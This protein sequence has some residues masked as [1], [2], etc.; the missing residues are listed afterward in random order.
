VGRLRIRD[1]HERAG[2][3]NHVVGQHPVRCAYPPQRIGT[4]D[5]N[6]YTKK[7]L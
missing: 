2:A 3:E 4:Q 5:S 7:H 1:G 6:S